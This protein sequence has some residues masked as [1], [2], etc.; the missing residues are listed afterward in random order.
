MTNPESER[1][2]MPSDD[3]I[4]AARKYLRTHPRKVYN[5]KTAKKWVESLRGQ[6]IEKIPELPVA[7]VSKCAICGYLC[8]TG[9]LKDH[10]TRA[11]RGIPSVPNSQVAM[12]QQLFST[13]M[14]P[15]YVEV[16]HDQ[17]MLP[18]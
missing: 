14:L 15:K 7:V 18:P 13:I 16:Y 1:D 5:I 6:A 9:T 3:D 12:S 2:D 11:H 17:D 10:F 8:K 4:D